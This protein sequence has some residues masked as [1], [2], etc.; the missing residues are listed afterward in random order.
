MI[1]KIGEKEKKRIITYIVVAAGL[2]L[3]LLPTHFYVSSG[4]GEINYRYCYTEFRLLMLVPIGGLTTY[5]IAT[6][7]KKVIFA[8]SGYIF[9]AIFIIFYFFQLFSGWPLEYIM[10]GTY[11]DILFF[12]VISYVGISEFKEYI[13][14]PTSN[15]SNRK[16][17]V[18]DA[19]VL[20]KYKKL[21]DSGVITQEEF[22]EKKKEIFD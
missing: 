6:W 13:K 12:C 16:V 22:D 10:V 14:N 18:G 1:N 11:F 9:Y 3:L 20:L 2:F 19:E 5:V 8:F 15:T 4:N 7:N 17:Q 21:L